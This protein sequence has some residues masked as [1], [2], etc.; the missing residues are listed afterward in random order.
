MADTLFANVSA[1]ICNHMNEDHGDAVV[2]YAQAF[3]GLTTATT[4]F[5]PPAFLP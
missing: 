3:G 1:R 2:L 4:N 5:L